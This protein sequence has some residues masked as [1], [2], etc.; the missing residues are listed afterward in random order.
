[1]TASSRRAHG[2]TPSLDGLTISP[3]TKAKTGKAALVDSWDDETLSSEDE[4]I[5][6]NYSRPS[7]PSNDNETPGPPP[8]TPSSPTHFHKK[9]TDWANFPAAYSASPRSPTSPSGLANTDRRP[10]KSSAA[11]GRLIAGALGVKTP[12]QSE[13]GKAYEKAVR[14]KEK[15]RREKAREENGRQE[16]E[17]E[18]AKRAVWDD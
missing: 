17:K 11:A 16:R 4:R 18:E 14:E 10:E 2:L 5:T 15:K 13:E 9:S 7:T 6:S 3:S 8:P 12:K 1:M